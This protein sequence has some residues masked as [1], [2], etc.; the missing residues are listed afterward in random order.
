[1]GDDDGKVGFEARQQSGFDAKQTTTADSFVPG[2]G[3]G[4]PHGHDAGAAMQ[5]LR[6]GKGAA[7][8]LRTTILPALQTQVDGGTPAIQTP[9]LEARSALR[10]L[11]DAVEHLK[12]YA[13]DK[14]VKS[15]GLPD[16]FL[17]DYQALVADQAVL[18][19]S[20]EGLIKTAHGTPDFVSRNQLLVGDLLQAIDQSARS[21]L[22]ALKGK[23][24]DLA[25]ANTAAVQL[26]ARIDHLVAVMTLPEATAW[27]TTFKHD[28]DIALG[29]AEQFANDLDHAGGASSQIKLA[30]VHAAINADIKAR[31]S[32]KPHGLDAHKVGDGLMRAEGL[33]I[34]TG[35][36][37]VCAI[38]ARR[39]AQAR[40]PE[41]VKDAA[42]D[43]RVDL[44]NAHREIALALTDHPELRA[45]I[46]EDVLAAGEALAALEGTAY[47]LGIG[48]DSFVTAMRRSETAVRGLVNL[49]AQ[50]PFWDSAVP[51]L[52]AIIDIIN[53]Y[54]V[55]ENGVGHDRSQPANHPEVPARYRPLLDEWFLITHGT[56]KQSNG[57][58]VQLRGPALAARI[59]HAIAET[60]ALINI[61][62]K[63]ADPKT[64]GILDDF[65]PKVT[66]FRHRATEETVWDAVDAKSKDA[67]EHGG[68][69]IDQL[70]EE[71]QL[72]LTSMRL[73][74]VARALTSSAQRLGSADK[75]IAKIALETFKK[76]L[77]H[78][79]VPAALK[80]K[81]E[82]ATSL[83][84]VANH[85]SGL[86][87]GINAVLN[88]ADPDQRK[89]LFHTEFE[90][91]GIAGGTT[92]ILKNLGGLAQGGVAAYSMA[93]YAFLRAK[94]APVDASKLFSGASKTLSNLSTAVNVLNIV[95]GAIMIIEGET[96]GEKVNGAV[97]AIWGTLGVIGRF[98]PRLARFTGPLS[99]AILIGWTTISWL[100]E[101]TMAALYGMIRLALTPAFI[102][103]QN[104]ARDIHGEAVRLATMIEMGSAFH[105]PDQI[106]E[107]NRQVE[108]FTHI[109][110]ASIKSYV[111]R[112]QGT[113]GR[114][115]DP[116]SWKA[117]H[118]RFKPL[119][120]VQLNST[121]DVLLASEQF[122]EIAVGCFE[123]AG[124][125]LEESVQQSL[126]EHG[127]RN[128]HRGI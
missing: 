116:G 31:W 57:S 99:A 81:L 118:T 52:S 87:N 6:V 98:V 44:D 61:I 4:H 128:K 20:V 92:E 67:R 62:E 34:G 28:A 114:D 103:L 109:L 9:Q 123:N 59:D 108:Q 26:A 63:E 120:G 86:A 29:R 113:G 107:L 11:D 78:A 112:S 47:K 115:S 127:E 72:K 1:M 42:S 111:D 16:T 53:S 124:Q 23:S 100:G 70:S 19:Q 18:K 2:K 89:K 41:L 27:L 15:L 77:P 90:K 35:T 43:C 54:V 45:G 33:R 40:D 79:E 97:E 84:D 117:F 21:G 32:W 51:T 88:V 25:A 76:E 121:F 74:T 125:I 48:E 73:I 17:A 65:F 110:A 12:S 60:M 56:V 95:H 71:H 80:E 30:L 119:V 38:R 24:P 50:R 36:L 37:G 7:A 91:Y 64:M 85:I 22:G 55:V 10:R 101:K 93:G 66:A 39:F 3:D 75:N 69:P 102:E 126:D 122:L 58:V 82:S 104:Q 46:V 94:G 13:T 105:D 49:P 96:T 5:E 83:S 68:S 14:T 106:K 8:R